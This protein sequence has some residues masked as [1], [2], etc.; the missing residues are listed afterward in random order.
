MYVLGMAGCECDAALRVC[1]D[2]CLGSKGGRNRLLETGDGRMDNLAGTRR[3]EERREGEAAHQTSPAGQGQQPLVLFP[4]ACRKEMGMLFKAPPMVCSSRIQP[5][6][7]ER[8]LPVLLERAIVPRASWASCM[9]LKGRETTRQSKRE[10][11]RGWVR[12]QN[13]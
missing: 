10:K 5:P 11:N 2:E 12:G 9:R 7:G 1:M 6:L 13:E 8:S 4:L 3:S